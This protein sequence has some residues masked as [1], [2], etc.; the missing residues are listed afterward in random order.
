[1]GAIPYPSKCKESKTMI[2]KIDEIK[3]RLSR[4]PQGSWEDMTTDDGNCF[5]VAP[6]NHAYFYGD[7]EDTDACCHYLADF[8]VHAESDIRFLLSELERRLD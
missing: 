3:A 4:I 6:E 1:M 8:I 2:E 5:I 7:L